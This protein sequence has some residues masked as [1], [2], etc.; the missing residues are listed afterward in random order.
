M[1]TIGRPVAQPVRSPVSAAASFALHALVFSVLLYHG[2]HWI[3]PIRYPG[4]AQGHNIVLNYLPGRAPAVAPPPR[5]QPIE[6]KSTLA[7]KKPEP[8]TPT[9]TSPNRNSPASDH[10]DSASGADALGSGNISIA[11]AKYF[12]RPKPDLTKLP[13]GTRCDVILDI[14]ID[15]NGRIS[16]LKLI[17]GVE[18]SVDEVVI[19]T[20]RSWTFNPANRDGQPVASEQELRFHYEKG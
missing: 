1:D 14:T 15:E 7:L 3:A 18:Q 9:Q 19:A 6:T 11:L 2:R 17:K 4:T 5:A 10:P 12:P 16:D 13:S 20:V 8:T